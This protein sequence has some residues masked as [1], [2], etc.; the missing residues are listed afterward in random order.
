MINPLVVTSSKQLRQLLH[1]ERRLAEDR[2]KLFRDSL[3]PLQDANLELARTA[4]Q[5]GRESILTVLLAQ[6]SL[7]RTKLDYAAAARDLAVSTAN[8]E[9]QLA[10]PIPEPMPGGP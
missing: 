10:G 7:I 6:E 1:R 5:S 3:V 2:V 8:L 9:R 4:Y